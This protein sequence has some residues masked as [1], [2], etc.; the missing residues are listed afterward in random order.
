MTRK[1]YIIIARVIKDLPVEGKSPR[2]IVCESF[3]PELQA[4]NANFKPDKFR[5]ACGL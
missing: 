5:T 1:D 4:D 2:I 3:I